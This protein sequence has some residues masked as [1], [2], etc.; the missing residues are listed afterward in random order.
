MN[1][2]YGIAAIGAAISLSRLQSAGLN[3]LEDNEAH[4]RILRAID[5]AKKELNLV[6]KNEKKPISCG[7]QLKSLIIGHRSLSA[8]ATMAESIEDSGIRYA[9]E[10]KLHDAKKLG[11]EKSEFYKLSGCVALSRSY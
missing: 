2:L 3:G 8:A 10:Q 1:L 6:R 5:E 7:D 11:R 9:L 4:R